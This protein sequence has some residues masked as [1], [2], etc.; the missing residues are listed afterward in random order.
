MRF[1]TQRYRLQGND[2]N[3]PTDWRGVK[4]VADFNGNLQ[5][6][7]SIESLTFVN[8][9]I[10]PIND[11]INE[12]KIFEGMDLEIEVTDEENTLTAF[13]GL[14][15]PSSINQITP[16][17]AEFNLIAKNGLDTINDRLEGLTALNL[18]NKGFLRNQTDVNFVVEPKFD[19]VFIVST[20]ISIFLLSKI[21]IESI[22]ENAKDIKNISYWSL[23]IPVPN[24]QISAIDGAITLSI[25]LIYTSALILALS[26]LINDMLKRFIQPIRVHKAISWNSVLSD[27]SS[28]LGYG[29]NTSIPDLDKIIQLP[30]NQTDLNTIRNGIPTSSDYGY[31]LADF[32][33]QVLL[34]FNCQMGVFDGVIQL[35]PVWSS[36]W[37]KNGTGKIEPT[38]QELDSFRYNTDSLIRSRELLFTYDLSEEFTSNESYRVQGGGVIEQGIDGVKDLLKG[39]QVNQINHALGNRKDE[40]T[41][42]ESLLKSLGKI[43]DTLINTFGGS[44]NLAGKID[45]RIGML[46]TS[47]PNHSVSKLLYMSGGNL[48]RNHGDKLNA[49]VIY[50]DYYLP[51]SFANGGQKKVY[52]GIKVPFNLKIFN[53]FRK[54]AYFIGNSGAISKINRIEWDIDSD[55]AVVDYEEDFTYTN[56]LTEILI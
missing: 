28:Y 43:A 49:D 40:L 46:R 3:S 22:K 17:K 52:E 47:T 16:N 51:S 29:F 15:D 18:Y 12:G 7:L 27:V 20:S 4:I 19:A 32:F 39:Y 23:T 1:Q 50:K 13:D 26:V 6:K 8:E 30:S 14:L 9:A 53:S 45:S 24:A 44:S 10:N 55:S 11:H 31:N 25:N 33:N 54:N 36:F 21:L 38:A 34:L 56:K 2:I 42:L 35:H 37:L 48:P 41:E 5:P